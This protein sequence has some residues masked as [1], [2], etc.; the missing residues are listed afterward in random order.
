MSLDIAASLARR[1][2]VLAQRTTLEGSGGFSGAGF[3]ARGDYRPFPQ[4]DFER[5]TFSEL[6]KLFPEFPLRDAIRGSTV[7]DLGCGYGGKTVE[8]RMQCG[9]VRV[10]GIEPHSSMIDRAR[11]YAATRSVANVEFEVCGACSIPYADETFDLVLTHDVLEHVKDPRVTVNEIFRVLRP[12]G[13]SV[14]VFP[15][16]L[17]ALSHHLDYI[18]NIPGIHWLFSPQ[19]LV[20][21]VNDVLKNNP[22]FGTAPQPE[23]C[24]SF[25]G[26]RDVLPSLNGLSGVHLATLFDSFETVSMRR[27]GLGLRGLGF[28]ANSRLPVRIRDMVTGTVVCIHRKP[29]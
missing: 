26:V 27:I 8:Y 15:V 14:N 5:E 10:C 25:D 9:A 20:R 7:L 17:G 24:R 29:C 13:L 19:T 4:A 11:Q 6:F 18:V 12:R 2:I 1:L 28:L 16:Y 22:Q 23:P 21:A 3:A